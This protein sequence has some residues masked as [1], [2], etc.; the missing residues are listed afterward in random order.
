MKLEAGKEMDRKCVLDWLNEVYIT[1]S[2]SYSN[3]T[4]EEIRIFA[5]DALV[6]LKEQQEEIENL[7]QTAQ[8][9]MEGIVVSQPQIV[10]CKD[11]VHFCADNIPEDGCG[12]CEL[13]SRTYR[14]D[15]Y[16][17]DGK[18]RTD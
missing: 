17:A 18:R 5:H 13:L 2:L 10:R 11:C 8:S 3:Y 6:L 12:F 16:C 1:P 14:A 9:M 4:D 7:K 15:H